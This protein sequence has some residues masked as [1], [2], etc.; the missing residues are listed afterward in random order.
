MINKNDLLNNIINY[1]IKKIELNEKLTDNNLLIKI[2]CIKD[3]LEF[4]DLTQFF[5]KKNLKIQVI[6]QKII[7]IWMFVNI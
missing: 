4:G 1:S 2:S 3:N 5:D 7:M 6:F